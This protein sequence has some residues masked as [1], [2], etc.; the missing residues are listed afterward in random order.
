MDTTVQATQCSTDN[1]VRA[2]L[3]GHDC[4][5]HTVQH[6]QSRPCIHR[7]DADATA[8]TRLPKPR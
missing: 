7:R 1:P 4:P 5:S 3:L 2:L 8:W 6:G